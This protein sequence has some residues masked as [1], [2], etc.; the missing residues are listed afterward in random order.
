MTN[1]VQLKISKAFQ[2]IAVKNLAEG[3]T[4]SGFSA[5]GIRGQRW[6]LRHKGDTYPFVRD[7]DNSPL[8]YL[9]VVIVGMSP[10]TSKLYFGSD[11]F[12]DET[13]SG[14]ICSS[15]RG[16]APDPGVS[17]PQA[18]A[19]PI[20]PHYG[21]GT[22]RNGRGKACQD[23]KRLAVML[24][25]K[26]TAKMLGA[27]LLEPVFFKVPPASLTSLTLYADNLMHQGLPYE[28]IVTRMTF[29]PQKQ[30]E[31]LFEA[32]EALSDKAAEV[33]LPL[34]EDRTTL[35]IVNGSTGAPALPRPAAA[36]ASA[37]EPSG[38]DDL[39]SAFGG[40]ATNGGE[41]AP[42]PAKRKGRPPKQIAPQV[43]EQPAYVVP[44]TATAAPG[45]GDAAWED[46]DPGLDSD[47]ARLLGS[48]IQDMMK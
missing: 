40:V 9:D 14:P 18:K 1:V 21:W 43:V 15:I 19:C 13:A 8:T 34:L 17:M 23:N 7:D 29:N 47:V 27:P 44:T 38:S 3:V 42:A 22:G 25:P 10:Y 6:S 37:P 30:F 41:D 2:H 24:M 4:I 12:N 11:A 20:C 26:M 31:I 33:V 28:A 16:D 45:E 39:V 35:Q 32:V 36:P 46:S 48:K 5:I